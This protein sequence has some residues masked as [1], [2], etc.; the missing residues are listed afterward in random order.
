MASQGKKVKDSKSMPNNLLDD[1]CKKKIEMNIDASVSWF[2]MGS[3]GY[4]R[5]DMPILTD[6]TY[7]WLAKYIAKHWDEIKHPYKTL[8]D[9][10]SLEITSSFE[11]QE[12]NYPTSVRDSYGSLVERHLKPMS[13]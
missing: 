4:Y 2:L 6:G 10:E 11:L 8:L 3:Y 1:L 12:E 7:D 5:R 9:K 13:A